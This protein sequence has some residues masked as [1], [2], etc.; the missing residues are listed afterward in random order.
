[1][2]LPGP[3][4]LVINSLAWDPHGEAQKEWGLV[5]NSEFPVVAEKNEP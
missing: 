3:L 1:M 5:I 2:E 4:H